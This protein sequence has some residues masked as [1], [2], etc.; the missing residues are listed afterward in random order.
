MNRGS[1]RFSSL[2][3]GKL[4]KSN[5]KTQPETAQAKQFSTDAKPRRDETSVQIH[6]MLAPFAIGV[7]AISTTHSFEPSTS[8]F[9]EHRVAVHRPVLV[10]G[11][12]TRLP[13]TPFLCINVT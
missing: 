4:W 5:E 6:T 8:L 1:E 12:H 7:I 10:K 11:P 13:Q 9:V 3:E 2:V